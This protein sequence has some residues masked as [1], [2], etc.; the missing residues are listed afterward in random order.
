M[1]LT[2]ILIRVTNSAANYTALSGVLLK[3]ENTTAAAALFDRLST[4]TPTTWLAPTNEVRAADIA[5]VAFAAVPESISSNTTLLADILSYHVLD[6][7]VNPKQ[8][9]TGRLRMIVRSFY[10]NGLLPGNRS[11]VVIIDSL[12][13]TQTGVQTLA[14]PY[15]SDNETVYGSISPV[16]GTNFT[17][18]PIDAVLSLPQTLSEAATTYFPSSGEMLAQAGL[19]QSLALNKGITVF[20][21][22]DG[23]ISDAGAV[24]LPLNTT[25]VQTLLSNHVI[26]GTVAYSSVLNKDNYTSVEGELFKFSANTTG[27]YVTSGGTTA[28]LLAIDIPIANGVVH[29]IDRVLNNPNSNPEAA[30]SAASSYAAQATRTATETST[31]TATETGTAKDGAAMLS[32]PISAGTVGSAVAIFAGIFAGA[33]LI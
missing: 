26:N 4:S 12:N 22:T 1:S 14:L 7:Y 10:N 2:S 5:S 13:D 9:E 8:I 31:G 25:Q 19:L 23:A 24:M 16:S 28:R 3:V 33:A 27:A 6:A 17:I 11:Q 32:T 20:A 29:I 15:Q 18:Y 21:P 30:Q